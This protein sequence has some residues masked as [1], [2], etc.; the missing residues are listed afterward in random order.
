MIFQLR[1][2]EWISGGTK[3]STL[4]APG[5]AVSVGLRAEFW[6]AVAA[7]RAV[8]A[9]CAASHLPLPNRF[10]IAVAGEAIGSGMYASAAAADRAV[11]DVMVAALERELLTVTVGVDLSNLPADQ[12][13]AIARRT[14]TRP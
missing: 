14:G 13:R 1:T 9:V 5:A 4:V 11:E 6:R 12:Q 3:K 8:A 2:V 7:H 10:L